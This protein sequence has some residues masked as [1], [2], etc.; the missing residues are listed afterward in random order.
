MHRRL[1]QA[2]ESYF[3]LVIFICR[4]I[5]ITSMHK[6]TIFFFLLVFIIV[7]AAIYKEITGDTEAFSNF[8]YA[9]GDYP[10]SQEGPILPNTDFPHTNN[11]GVSGCTAQMIW[12]N[13]PIFEV[14]SYKQETNNIRYPDNPDNGRCTP[15]D[16]CGALYNNRK[17]QS[18]VVSPLSPVKPK[19]GHAR[20]NY[21]TTTTGNMFP[22]Y[23]KGNI[24]Y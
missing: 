3:T 5:Y 18:N 14:C 12:R 19:S 7:S 8:R 9:L 15:A 20:V 22:F 24:L 4:Y 10:A 6:N 13:Y 17:P 11:K 23:N 1:L 16:M 21:Y 2:K